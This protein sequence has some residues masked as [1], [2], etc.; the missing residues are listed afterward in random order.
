MAGSRP[1]V[2]N[3]Y[4]TFWEGVS[5]FVFKKF[6][7]AAEHCEELEKLKGRLGDGLGAI[8]WKEMLGL[9]RQQSTEGLVLRTHAACSCTTRDGSLQ[10]RSVFPG[11]LGL[12]QLLWGQEV[13]TL[14]TATVGVGRLLGQGDACA[15]GAEADQNGDA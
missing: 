7:L 6:T 9:F 3:E 5:G 10:P 11:P 14:S 12:P 2:S 15:S 13:A 4:R 8:L 1:G